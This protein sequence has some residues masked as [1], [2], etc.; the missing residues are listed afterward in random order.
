M[1]TALSLF[2]TQRA[3]P[4]LDSRAAPSMAPLATDLAQCALT[5]CIFGWMCASLFFRAQNRRVG[6]YAH[7]SGHAE[8]ILELLL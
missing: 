8:T 7:V 6:I 1:R 4:G 2:V 3:R 5:M